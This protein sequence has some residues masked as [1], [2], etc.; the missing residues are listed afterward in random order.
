MKIMT[1]TTE[2]Q[3]IIRVIEI[4][5]NILYETEKKGTGDVRPHNAL[6]KGELLEKITIKNKASPKG[7]NLSISIYSN[8]TVWDFKKQVALALDLAP[9]Y[10][11]LERVFGY[12]SYSTIKENENGKTLAQLG[13]QSGETLTAYKLQVEEE[14][15]NAPLTGPDGQLTEKAKEI[16]NEWFDMYSDNGKMTKETCSLFIKGCTGEQ[17]SPND[18]R[19]GT[20][21]KMYDSNND[22]FIEREEFLLFY[23]ISS[24]NK[25]ETVRENLRSH[26]IRND[27]K[28]LSEVTEESTFQT[29][30]MPRYRISRNQQ[31]FDLL[32]SLLDRQDKVSEASWD[33]IQMLAT[34]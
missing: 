8:A 32:I 12:S 22:G 9:K 27:L 34:N 3:T 20:L 4:I 10:L 15:V 14:V 33:L 31:Q 29:E 25:P 7:Q 21:F 17:P 30:D 28:K 1:E 13:L 5:K 26:N 24:K 18:D 16:F 11:K 23:Q 2:Q 6:L 19:I